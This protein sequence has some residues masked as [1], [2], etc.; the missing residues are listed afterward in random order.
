MSTITNAVKAA[1]NYC[2]LEL[3]RSRPALS[4]QRR[5]ELDYDVRIAPRWG[6]GLEANKRIESAIAA[7]G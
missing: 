4:K 5:L 6:Y 1:F 7:I 3:A 2:G